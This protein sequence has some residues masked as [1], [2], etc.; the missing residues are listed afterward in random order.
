MSVSY[1][2]DETSKHPVLNCPILT[3]ANPIVDFF[4]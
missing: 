3:D 4:L 2:N 1:L